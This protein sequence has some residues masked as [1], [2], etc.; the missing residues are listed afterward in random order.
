MIKKNMSKIKIIN[1]LYNAINDCKDTEIDLENFYYA[2]MR[3]SS[4]S[5]PKLIDLGKNNKYIN[6]KLSFHNC[7]IVKNDNLTLKSY[8]E[9]YF[10][11]KKN[12]SYNNHIGIEFHTFNDQVSTV[13][14]SYSVL[15]FYLS[16]VLIAGSYVRSFLQGQPEKIILTEMPES[17]QLVNLCEGI[18]T[19]RFSF[20]L[21]KEEHLYYVLIELMRSPD[22]LKLL[23]KSSLQQF[24]DRKENFKVKKEE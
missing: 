4:S 24:K 1:D 17:E 20:D 22:Y 12:E 11:I 18:K 9:S 2:P 10:Q 5:H 8:T 6:I 16:F 7:K 19:A 15:T 23:T 13:T 21:E 14:S 3:L